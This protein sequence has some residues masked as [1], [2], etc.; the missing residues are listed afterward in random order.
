M[1]NKGTKALK[2]VL[3]SFKK[4]SSKEYMELYNDL[5]SRYELSPGKDGGK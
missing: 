4:M 1:K 5:K 2:K 3:K